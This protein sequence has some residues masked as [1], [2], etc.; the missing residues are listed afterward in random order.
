MDVCAKEF[1]NGIIN[2]ETDNRYNHLTPENH[3][4]VYNIVSNYIGDKLEKFVGP[5]VQ[6]LH[7]K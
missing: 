4:V 6:Y 5:I 7:I 3:E 1:D 2:S